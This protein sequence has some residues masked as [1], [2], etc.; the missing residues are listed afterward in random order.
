MTVA[1]SVITKLKMFLIDM[2]Y[3]ARY[4]EWIVYDMSDAEIIHMG[5]RKE[6]ISIQK[7][8]YGGLMVIPLKVKN[9]SS[10]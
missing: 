7:K 5:K 6:C 1:E 8:S 4:R 3:A 2:Y 10:I 9:G